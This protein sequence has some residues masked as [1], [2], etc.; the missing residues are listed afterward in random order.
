MKKNLLIL[1]LVQ[2]HFK[3]DF[4]INFSCGF[5]RTNTKKQD[6]LSIKQ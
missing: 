5:G 2:Y 1:P 3:V 6:F 4:V